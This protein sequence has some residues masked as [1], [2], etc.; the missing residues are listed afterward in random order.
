MTEFKHE[1]PGWVDESLECCGFTLRGEDRPEALANEKQVHGQVVHLVSG[2]PAPLEGDGLWTRER[3]LVLAVRVADCVPVL[4]YD[5]GVPAVAAVHAGWR[6]TAVDIVGAAVATGA[7]E[8]GVQPERLRAALGPSIGPC[9]FEVGHEVVAALRAL[10]LDEVQIGLKLGERGKP[11]VD[12]RRANRA[13]LLRAGLRAD[14]IEDVGDCT[15]CHPGRYESYRRDGPSSGRMRGVIGLALLTLLLLVSACASP[16]TET[17]LSYG[18]RMKEAQAAVDAGEGERAEGL[19][20]EALAMAPGDALA[21]AELARALHQQGRTSEAIV[22]GHQAVGLDPALWEAAYNLACH[23]TAVGDTEAAIRW[24]QQAVILGQ[25]GPEE[26][27]ADSDLAALTED[28][29]FVFFSQTGLLSRAEEDAILLPGQRVVE[30]GDLSRVTLV[31][32]AL[33]R[34]LMAKREA[35]DVTLVS[36]WPEGLI[37]PVE[38]VE[39][40]STG[41]IGGREYTQRSIQYGFRPLKPGFLVLGPFRVQHGDRTLYVSA[42][43]IQVRPGEDESRAAPPLVSAGDFFR[44]PSIADEAWL[45]ALDGVVGSR[46]GRARSF[47]GLTSESLPKDLEAALPG[48]FRSAFLQRG[49]EGMS[50]VVDLHPPRGEVSDPG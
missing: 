23:Y 4:L 33:N 25:L 39:R 48:G 42:E 37:E 46:Q 35:M 18:D 32:L 6:G 49:T 36:D 26:V 14:R 30:V 10:E 15:M 45:L 29:R 11:H 21:H 28:H 7:S 50:H 2:G 40:F 5:P 16:A 8:L 31:V 24:L 34:P 3:G 43:V 9:C 13:L 44:P 20:A 19:L 1:Q 38:R 22:A 17:S 27:E 47:R 41:E 12:L